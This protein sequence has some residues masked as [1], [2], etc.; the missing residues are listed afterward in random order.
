MSFD[1][2]AVGEGNSAVQNMSAQ[3]PTSYTRSLDIILYRIFRRKFNTNTTKYFEE[4]N[5]AYYIRMN[6]F[7]NK[8][9]AQQVVIITI[10]L[11]SLLCPCH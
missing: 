2:A 11:P 3:V 10:G 6:E 7:K 1:K 4:L 8:F 5:F 9:L